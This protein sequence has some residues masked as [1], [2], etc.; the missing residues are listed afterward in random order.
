VDQTI[1]DMKRGIAEGRVR[2]KIVMQRVLE[3]LNQQLALA[4][5]DS[6]FYKPFTTFP[7]AVPAD[8]G[9]QLALGGQGA[10]QDQVMPALTRLR[11]FIQ[12][13]AL[14]AAPDAVGLSSQPDGANYYAFLAR[15][16]TTT[17]LSPEAIHELGI[18]EVA[19]IRNE[20]TATMKQSGFKGSLAKF[21]EMLRT[22]PRFRYAT[23]EQLLDGYRV[24][25]KR[26]DP[27]LPRLFGKLPRLT[28][29][30]RAIPAA[31]AAAAPAAYY[32]PGAADGS[33]AGNV[34]VNLD[35]PETRNTWEMEALMLHE[36]VPGHHLQ[37]ALG[38]EL[39]GLP[40]FRR[41]GVEFTA[42]V[43]GWGLYSESL[44]SE[45]GLYQDP[46]TKFGRLTFEMWRAVRLVV[47]TGL[48]TKKWTRQK[49][50]DYFM[51]NAP[52]S[53][54]EVANEVDRYIA[55]PGQ[56]LA[57]KLGELRIQALRKRAQEALGEHFD[58]R[59]FHDVVLG[60]GALP[61]D[62]LEANVDAWIAATKEKKK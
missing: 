19:R 7:P 46:Y 6:P 20:M 50:I 12:K 40:D 49:A 60:S 52:K 18:Q 22:D 45:V 10:I 58:L 13:D 26:I 32:F 4:P 9:Q 38:Q 47:D 43:E 17:K 37:I 5:Q 11:D 30:V 14:P 29:G 2:P 16:H 27:E 62:V 23:P 51:D 57:Y 48:H 35:K 61:L 21:F 25:A 41:N 28:Y 33:R 53:E 1:G 42:F 56:A 31:A 3:Q 54:P 24:I 59:A 44:G 55:N 39:Q 8:V 36:A 34:Y 15:F